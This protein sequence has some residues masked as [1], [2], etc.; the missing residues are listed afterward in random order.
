MQANC[1]K[2]QP[3]ADETTILISKVGSHQIEPVTKV[4]AE[5]NKAYH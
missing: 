2:L 3:C 5:G 1:S 4:T